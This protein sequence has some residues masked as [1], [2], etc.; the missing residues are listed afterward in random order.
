MET[1]A[2]ASVRRPDAAYGAQRARIT[3]W[4]ALALAPN[5]RNHSGGP[6]SKE[7]LTVLVADVRGFSGLCERSDATVL[8]MQVGEHLAEMIDVMD[9]TCGTVVHFMGDGL[10]GVFTPDRGFPPPADRAIHAALCMHAVQAGLNRAWSERRLP[11]FHLG[12]GI[13][14]G[15]VAILP[16]GPADRIEYTVLGDTVNLAERLQGWA[17]AGETVISD[18]TYTSLHRHVQA[19][20]LEPARVRGRTALVSARRIRARHGEQTSIAVCRGK[21]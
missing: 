1:G 17:L 19:E 13:S 3:L 12:I 2:P 11:P 7:V 8:A 6:I 15:E 18:T 21:L 4:P 16:I 14:T 9:A 10:L 20:P 5:R